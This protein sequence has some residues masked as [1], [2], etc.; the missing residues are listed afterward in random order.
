LIPIYPRRQLL[1]ARPH[2]SIELSLTHIEKSELEFVQ[3]RSA[4]LFHNVKLLT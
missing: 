4:W 3:F 1:L 2:S